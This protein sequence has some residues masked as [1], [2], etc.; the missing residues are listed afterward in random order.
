MTTLLQD[1]RHGLRLL[2]KQP[3][4]TLV[5]VVTLALGIG[6]NTAIFSVVNGVL[7][8]PLPYPA[9]ERLLTARQNISLLNL[10]DIRAQ[11]RSYEASGGAVLQ[12]LD[13]TGGGE[14]VQVEAALFTHEAL[15]VL[16]ARAVVGRAIR[17][18][19]ERTGGERLALVS[20]GFWQ[21]QL[22]GRDI[23]GMT[24]PLSGQT[25]S[26][27]GVLA[28]SFA[29]PHGSPDVWASLRVVNP[30]AAE[31]R[32]VHF[33]RTYWRLKAGVVQAEAQAEL[34]TIGGRLAQAYP[35]ENKNRRFALM[36]L[37]ERMVG[38]VR[39]ALLVLFG[40]VGLVLLIA[41][42]NFANLLLAR[43]ASRAQEMAVRTALGAGRLRIVRQMLT[44]SVLLALAGGAGGLA[45]AV[46]GVDALL[47]L[48]PESLPRAADV[49]IDAGV[50][51]FTL[52]VS[53]LAGLVF[54]LAPAWR[55][56][57]ANLSDAL[58]EGGRGDS[59]GG[60]ARQRLRSTLIV[61]EL[62]MALVLLVCAGLLIKAFWRLRQVEPGFVTAGLLTMRVELPE[63]RYRE[64]PAQTE[65][66]RRALEALNSLPGAEAAMVS[67][68]PLTDDALH[69]DF[70]IDG[71]PPVAPGDE[72]S[73]YSRSVGGEYM[74]V[75]R[76]PLRAG[77]EL[78]AG[79][80]ANAPAVGV[81]N[82]SFARRYFPGESPLGARVRWARMEPAEWITIVGVV[83]DV[84][85]FGLDQPEEP[86]LYTPY[87]QSRQAWKR[88]MHLVVR[89]DEAPATLARAVKSKVWSVDPQIPVTKVLTMTEVSAASVG[90]QRFNM[91]LLGV[92]ASVAL[93]LAAVGI[94]GVVSYGVTQ[95]T[96]EIGVRMALG[97]QTG[98]VLRLVLGQ[99]TLLALAGVALGLAGAFA[100]SRLLASLLF[101][102]STK[103]PSVYAL[104]SA[105]LVAVALLATYFPARRATK[106]DPMTALRYE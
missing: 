59:G 99:G 40:A 19:E 24:I 66:R 8:K 32:G 71:R 79:D 38:D 3:G 92:F 100:L 16:G 102:V 35:D 26:V 69:H 80:D 33:L 45:L 46:W 20:Y 91:T 4:F 15:E 37:Q 94:Y 105:V 44:E 2:L 86:A 65:F 76:I 27:V 49:R 93:L 30:I 56:S 31:H 1:L 60:L 75:M 9:P 7:L 73:L 54:G 85:H 82:E 96:R 23:E 17:P 83:G 25:Y 51:L 55:A 21:R 52:G 28:P 81:V 41:C 57:R 103:D 74:K 6:A 12:Q 13:Y 72:P 77:R 88:W 11:A 47:A 61:V 58:K 97:A 84:K 62:A 101:G 64:I 89:S 29:P 48:A 90:R 53:V 10:E 68:L 43:A 50:L 14:P 5:A 106:V 98:D 36:P 42:A 18:E 22:G 63:A 78:S 39:P 87:A 104:V 34:D 67:E 70:V 95:R